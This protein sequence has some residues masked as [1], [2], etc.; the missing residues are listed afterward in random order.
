MAITL[1]SWARTFTLTVTDFSQLDD[2]ML[3][4]TPSIVDCGTVWL[5]C[6]IELSSQVTHSSR[7]LLTEVSHNS[8]IVEG[9]VKS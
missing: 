8:W 2:E 9:N 4:G 6:V 1:C 7:W 5:S 3:K